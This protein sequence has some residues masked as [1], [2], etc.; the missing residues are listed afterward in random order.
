MTVT[1]SR[2]TVTVTLRAAELGFHDDDGK[3]RVEPGPFKVF[4][5]GSSETVLEAEFRVV[6]R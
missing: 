1:V 3:L 6:G 4:A 5:G 2:R